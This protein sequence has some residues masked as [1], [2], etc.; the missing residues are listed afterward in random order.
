[1][2]LSFED[3]KCM[4]LKIPARRRMGVVAAQAA[5]TLEAVARAEAEGVIVPVLYGR[6][7]LILP[8]WQKA[9]QGADL[10]E[11][12]ECSDKED[13]ITAALADVNAGYLDCIMKGKLET[14][15]LMKYVVN[16]ENG[17]RLGN[18]LSLVAMMESPY[19]HKIFA[20]TDVGMMTYPTLEQKKAILENAVRLFHT[21][22]VKRPKV[23]V[24]A[25]VAGRI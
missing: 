1:M 7:S 10:P 22:G 23:A 21:L 13:A 18:A 6:E 25:A 15:E 19:Y 5:H 3:I 17:I 11:V 2:L 9:S 16:R 4:I 20:V 12:R 8:I 24:L 14:G